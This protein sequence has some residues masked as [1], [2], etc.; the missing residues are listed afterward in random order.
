VRARISD[1]TGTG[2]D[3]VGRRIQDY[4]QGYA[5]KPTR[6]IGPA[7]QVGL[8][9]AGLL[10]T[11][12]VILLTAFYMALRPQPLIDGALSLFPS[13]RRADAER[14]LRDIRA[15]WLGWLRGVGID[16]LVSG[17]LLYVGLLIAGLDFALVF[18][19]TSAL[20]VV[21][22]Y[23]GAV[24][25]GVPPVLFALAESPTKALVV[26]GVYLLVQQIEGNVI[27][28]VVMSRQVSLHPAVIVIGVVIVGNL[29]GFVGL[30]VAVPLISAFLILVKAVWVDPLARDDDRRSV[31]DDAAGLT[32][33]PTSP[34]PRAVTTTMTTSRP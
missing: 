25:G 2:E 19:V 20:F 21:I 29:V 12:V 32:G 22:P 3:E 14:V 7:A 1:A 26:F 34:A 30:F 11:L 18:A 17:S 10:G 27:I 28:P 15:A 24:A 23:F 5:D 8:G 33:S 9:V 13:R 16:M 6:L 31:P 4:V